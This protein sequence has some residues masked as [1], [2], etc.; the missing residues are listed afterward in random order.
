VARS[1]TVVGLGEALFDVFADRQVLG[2]APLNVA[3]HAHQMAAA[4]GVRGV[5]ASRVGADDLGRRLLDEL[6]ARGVP[7]VGI[8]RD[9][10][11][12]T[13]TVLV[14]LRG[15]E[16]SYQIVEDTAWD[17]LE[18]TDDWSALARQADAVCFGTLGQRSPQ[19]R[20]TIE[21]FLQAAPQ[22]IRMFDVN[23]R[24]HYYSAGIIHHSCM[25]ATVVKLNEHELPEVHR[26]LGLSARGSSP[27]GHAVALREH[28]GLGAVVLTRGADGTA[29]YTAA[30][31]TEGARAHYPAQPDADSVG[32]GDA[33]AAGILLGMLQEWPPERV[34]TLANAAGAYVAS[35]PG[36]TPQLPPSL[37]QNGLFRE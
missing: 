16:P 25:L 28:F 11:R 34:V 2:G 22:A 3:V 21:L 4:L 37:L 27:D 12:P 14:T 26:L 9:A 18:F 35:Q 30:G 1:L 10:D 33:C 32:A 36:A 15:S 7:T 8:Q 19:A 29:L 24:Q 6:A 5:P 13:G 31:K 20:A 17:W 23:L